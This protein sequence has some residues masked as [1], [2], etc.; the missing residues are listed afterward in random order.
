MIIPYLI[1]GS[2]FPRSDDDDQVPWLRRACVELIKTGVEVEALVP[3]HR[4]L[5]S[6]TVDGITV[7]RF[8]YAPSQWE[9]LTGEEGAPA[10]MRRN[11][12]IKLLAIAYLWCGFWS[13]VGLL[14]KKHYDV[15]EVHW[16]FPH[17][18]MDAAC[19]DGRGSC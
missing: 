8:R 4:G 11:P 19:G 2:V 7:H 6:H 14:L 1:I 16:P 13:L 5:K 9:V 10:K 18:Y 3:A 17:A 12:M 15:V